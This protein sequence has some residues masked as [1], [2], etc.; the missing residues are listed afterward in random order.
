M[1]KRQVLGIEGLQFTTLTK[2]GEQDDYSVHNYYNYK[3]EIL[4]YLKTLLQEIEHEDEEYEIVCQDLL[5][6]RCV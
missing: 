3:H 5:E 1:Y 4:F 2:Q 6:V